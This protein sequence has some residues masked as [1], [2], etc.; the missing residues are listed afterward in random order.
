MIAVRHTC[1]FRYKHSHTAK[2]ETDHE[3]IMY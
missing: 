2:R 1:Q 3:I